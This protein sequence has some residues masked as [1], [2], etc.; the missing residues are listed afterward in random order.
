MPNILLANAGVPMLVLQ[1]PYMAI[2]LLPIIAIES[3]IARRCL[4][5][6]SSLAWHGVSIANAMSTFAGVPIAW[7][8]MLVLNI[9][10]TGTR[11]YGL[12][13]PSGVSL[14]SFC[15]RPG[16]LHRNSNKI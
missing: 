4:G 7:A 1:L 8:A 5:V 2:A 16:S 6:S 13:T 11:S 15:K 12:D 3:R 9:V 14:P 10:S